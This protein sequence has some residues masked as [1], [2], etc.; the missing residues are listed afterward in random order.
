VGVVIAA[1]DPREPDV[2]ALVATHLAFSREVTP[3]GHVHALA[4]DALTDPSVTVLAARRYNALIGIGALRDIGGRHAEI[5]SMHVAAGERGRGAGRALL[6]RLIA[7]AEARGAERVSLETGTMPAF[8]PARS[9][10]LNAGFVP[11]EP[12]GDYTANANSI[13]MTRTVV[14]LTRQSESDDLLV[15]PAVA[16]DVR[17]ITEILDAQLST[18]THEWTEVPHTV[19]ERGVW[20]R[21]RR[22]AGEPVLV[23]ECGGEV[24]GWAAYGEFRDTH[25]WPGYWP[26]VEHSIHVRQDSWSRGV[27]RT[28]IAALVEHALLAGKRVMVAAIDGTNQR[29]ISFHERLGFVVVG[30]LAGTGEKFGRELDLVLM[31]RRLGP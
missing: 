9:L 10:Y 14:P 31:Q 24:V 3:P 5:K 16:A 17:A 29:S 8:E 21:Q 11:C 28:L 18:T 23:A 1:A 12:F 25:R 2:A 4:V 26:T 19:E 20:L 27:G 15:R 30:Q 7:L 13:C 6:G 22:A